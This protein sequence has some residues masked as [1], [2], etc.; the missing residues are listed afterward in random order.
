VIKVAPF[1]EKESEFLKK[2]GNIIILNVLKLSEETLGKLIRKKVTAIAF[3]KIQT[4]TG[5]SSCGIDERN[6]QELTSLLIVFEYLSNMH[7]A[8][9][10]LGGITG[11]SYRSCNLGANTAGEFAARALSVLDQL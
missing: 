2:P 3:E 7:E 5:N 4:R 9:V 8:R 10:M 6:C 11:H 1:T